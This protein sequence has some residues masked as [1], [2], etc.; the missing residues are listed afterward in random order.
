MLL[1]A[2]KSIYNLKRVCVRVCVC[3]CVC[4]RWDG[5]HEHKPQTNQIRML[6]ASARSL[7]KISELPLI[8][9]NC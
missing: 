8:V 5:E 9:I 2:T 1:P 6:S 4:E 7:L 3:V